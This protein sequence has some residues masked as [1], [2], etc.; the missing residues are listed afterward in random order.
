MKSKHPERKE[1]NAAPTLF[2]RCCQGLSQGCFLLV[3][4]V[5]RLLY[6]KYR[7]EGLEHLPEGPC[8]VVGNHA[9]TNG[10]VSCELYFPGDRAIWC[11][12]EMFH[13]KEIPA[14]AFEDFWSD[15]K[16]SVRWIYRLLSYLIAPLAACVFQNAHTIPVYHDARTLSTFRTTLARLQR[17]ARIIIFPEHAVPHNAIVYEFRQNFVQIAG[18]YYRRTGQRLAF[19]PMYVA[20][21]LHALY[22]GAP[23]YYDPEAPEAEEPARICDALMH[24]VTQIAKALPLHTVVPYPNI[25]KADYPKNREE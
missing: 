21:A 10:P 17:G 9:K 15:K 19:V 25:P 7:V 20:P 12:G 18:M 16:K 5:V 11:A 2:A 4:G 13:L 14:Y 23:V 8:I 22:L 3:R 1:K 6:P 24:A